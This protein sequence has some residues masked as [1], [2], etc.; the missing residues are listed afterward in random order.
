MDFSNYRYIQGFCTPSYSYIEGDDSETFWV[1]SQNCYMHIIPLP[2]HFSKIDGKDYWII[3]PM[4][5]KDI[6]IKDEK[7]WDLYVK[8][9]VTWSSIESDESLEWDFKLHKPIKNESESN[10]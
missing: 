7:D 10:N 5:P 3:E 1:D 2:D 8:Y 6:T 9:F 4:A